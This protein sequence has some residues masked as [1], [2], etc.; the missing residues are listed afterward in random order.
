MRQG[1][2]EAT[3]G[4]ASGLG[5]DCPSWP[6]EGTNPADA[7]ASGFWTPELGRNAFPWLKL[8]AGGPALWDGQESNAGV[9]L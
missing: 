4:P 1:A 9:G 7:W 5:T 3:R 6:S 2:P 8:P